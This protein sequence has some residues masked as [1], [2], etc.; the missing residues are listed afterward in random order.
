MGSRA[1]SIPLTTTSAGEELKR[2]ATAERALIESRIDG[3]QGGT[4]T[5]FDV[6]VCRLLDR[7][8]ASEAEHGWDPNPQVPR[9]NP[10]RTR[11]PGGDPKD[12]AVLKWLVSYLE[13]RKQGRLVQYEARGR[14][15]GEQ[16]E[17]R[18]PERM[19]SQGKVECL[20]WK[21]KPLFKSVFDFAIV[22]ML[23]WESKP[24]TVFE[25]GSG[26]GASACWM[27]DLLAAFG[28]DTPVYS[29]DIKPIGD[30]YPG[31]HFLGGD[32][33][34]PQTLFGADL[35][36]SAPH[37]FL[38]VEDAHENVHEVLRY[39]DEFAIAGDYLFIEDSIE[40][41]E[42]L[43]AFLAERPNRY[44]VDAHY[45]DFFGRN[46]TSAMDSILVRV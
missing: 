20:S 19:M 28:L 4:P 38:I 33:M 42:A 35:L 22:P 41:Q 40:K 14:R 10:F 8:T 45:A 44:L 13:S 5:Y 24:A 7:L 3:K 1:D 9:W 29:V 27:A 26:T 2:A 37:P 17:I 34:S 43:K 32:C 30:P 31:V 21:G 18:S 36:R 15:R 23:I 25:I 12:V 46:A 39:L 16:S 6:F 11:R